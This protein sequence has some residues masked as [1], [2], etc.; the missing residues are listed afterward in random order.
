VILTVLFV[1]GIGSLLLVSGL[2]RWF[3]CNA[4]ID[5]DISELARGVGVADEAARCED[6]PVEVSLT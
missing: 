5:A 2:S 6:N 1:L 3:T 4:R